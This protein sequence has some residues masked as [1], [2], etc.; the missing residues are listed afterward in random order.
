MEEVGAGG[1]NSPGLLWPK[2]SEEEGAPS[3][4]ALWS[5]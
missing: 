4:L 1:E 3:T 5:S 2:A